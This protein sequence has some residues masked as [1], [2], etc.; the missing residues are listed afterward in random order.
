MSVMGNT[1]TKRKLPVLVNIRLNEG[2]SATLPYSVVQKHLT[3]DR[4]SVEVIEMERN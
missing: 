4:E 1:S 3:L 2:Y